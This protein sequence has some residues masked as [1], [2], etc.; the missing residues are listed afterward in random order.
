MHILVL[1]GPNLNMLEHRDPAR[2]GHTSLPD[3]ASMLHREFDTVTTEFFQSNHE[4]ELVERIHQ[5]VHE[6]GVD[7]MLVN[8]GGLT[9]TS[10][11]L[12]DALAMVKVPK[13]EVHLSNIHAREPFRH[14]SLTGGVCDGIIAG[15]SANSYRYG[16][17]ALLDLINGRS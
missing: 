4:G 2:Y 6:G 10:V 17:Q 7:G 12:R 1:N 15:F 3:I 11:V 8:F 16:M 9:H 13:V 14:A 5:V